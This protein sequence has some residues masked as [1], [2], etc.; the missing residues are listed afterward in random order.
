MT[1]WCQPHWD[2]L[3][4]AVRV[5]GLDKFGAQNA[6]E[7]HRDMVDQ[8][9]GEETQFDPL[10]G[11]FWRLSNAVL[12]TAGLRAVGQCPMCILRDESDPELKLVD[13]WIDGVTDSAHQYAVEQ[14][15]IKT[16]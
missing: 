16:Q 15:L 13:D 9:Q 14:G 2:Q 5:R 11:S 12:E 1:K 8:A 6:E 7:A 10:M 4:E 3:R